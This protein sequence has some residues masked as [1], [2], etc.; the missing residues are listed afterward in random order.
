MLVLSRQINESIVIGDGIEITIV[1]IKGDKVRLGITAP[2][3]VAIHRKEVFAA[4]KD[5][6]V[7]AMQSQPRDVGA[8]GQLLDK[9]RRD[10]DGK[11]ST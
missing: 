3:H 6:N 8:A 5:A 7:D 4:I 10:K 2:A 1:D 11:P 9:K